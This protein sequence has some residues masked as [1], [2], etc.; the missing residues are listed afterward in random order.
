MKANASAGEA[1]QFALLRR[2]SPSLRHRLV[3]KMQP[4]AFT[5]ALAERHLRGDS[6]NL[7]GARESLTQIPGQIR[8]S[9]SFAVATLAWLTGEEAAAVPLS[10]GV[11]EFVGLIRTDCE[12]R[13]V[14]IVSAIEG[15]HAEVPRRA[16]RIM[17]TASLIALVDLS[18]PP[19][20][21]EVRSR[22]AEKQVELVFDV[23]FATVDSHFSPVPPDTRPLGWDDVEALAQLVGVQLRSTRTPLTATCVF[24]IV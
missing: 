11:E 9:M 23:H 6:P 14:T 3:G 1:A 8:E 17:L 4:I 22:L 24:D 18:P 13:G 15:I 7:S 5:A 21:I 16:L 2:V 10:E 12:M 19:S 20:R